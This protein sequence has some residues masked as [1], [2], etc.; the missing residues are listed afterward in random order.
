MNISEAT[1]I[2]VR[3]PEEFNMG[4]VSGSINIPLDT[5]P[6]RLEEI[7]NFKTPLVLCCASGGRSFAACQY[8][9]QQGLTDLYDGGPWHNV[10][11]A[12]NN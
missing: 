9:S 5:I 2:D 11:Q 6:H 10:N 8:L 4:N 3:T 7:K 1:I 12:L